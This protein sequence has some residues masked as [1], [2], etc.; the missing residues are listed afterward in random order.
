MKWVAQKRLRKVLILL[1]WVEYS[2]W[3]G[4]SSV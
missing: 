3:E 2:D 4:K 1:I